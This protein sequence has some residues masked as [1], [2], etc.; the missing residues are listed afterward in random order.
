[1]IG[2]G[3][4]VIDCAEELDGGS[5]LAFW[6]RPIDLVRRLAMIAAS[7]GLDHAGING[8]AFTL[9]QASI[10]AGPHHSLEQ[11][12]E[13]VAA[14]EPTVA[15]DR[16]RRVVRHPVVKIEPAEPPI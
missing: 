2:M 5:C 13:D 8:E 11:L 14:A 12:P 1:A 15:I 10:H 3:I 16:E 6:C 7:I 9:D 4:V